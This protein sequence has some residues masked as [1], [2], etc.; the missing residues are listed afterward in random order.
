MVSELLKGLRDRIAS[1]YSAIP[2]RGLS[3]REWGEIRRLP[4]MVSTAE[5]RVLFGYALRSTAAAVE[6]GTFFGA[7]AGAIASG[8]CRNTDPALRTAHLYDAFQSDVSHPF[9]RHVYERAKAYGLSTLLELESNR[10][11]WLKLTK[12]V[13]EP[14]QD[15]VTMNQV[16][17]DTGRKIPG[18]PDKI[19]LLHL[20]M[21]K[22]L[23]TAS[24]II[25]QVFNRCEKGAVIAYQDYYYHF[26]GDLIAF[27]CY[28][29]TSGYLSMEK[30]VDCTAYFRV[31]RQMP[32][33]L[34]AMFSENDIVHFLTLATRVSHQHDINSQQKVSL[35]MALLETRL[36]RQ[37]TPSDLTALQ[38][39]LVELILK[40]MQDDPRRTAVCLSQIVSERVVPIK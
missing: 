29:T 7:S 31:N 33:H 15:H 20:D 36:R 37:S 5:R 16:I 28:L 24:A 13:L 32:K 3:L 17:I 27:F 9:A 18:L 22:D 12:N 19:G 6:F 35:R 30:S 23:H 26:S 10:V 25:D 39:E 38:D 8:I 11:S 34:T 1:A 40:S 2:P 14:W 21:P 4:G